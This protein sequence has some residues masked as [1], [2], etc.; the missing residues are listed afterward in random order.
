MGESEKFLARMPHYLQGTAHAPLC[1]ARDWMLYTFDEP[2]K[3]RKCI[4]RRVIAGA[5][6]IVTTGAGYRYD[7]VKFEQAESWKWAASR[8]RTPGEPCGSSRHATTTR[9]PY[10][11]IQPPQAKTSIINSK[12]EDAASALQDL[13]KAEKQVLTPGNG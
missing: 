7:G 9:T 3:C 12:A 13:S 1:H 11:T 2:V 10:V 6:T 5:E 4:S 8:Q